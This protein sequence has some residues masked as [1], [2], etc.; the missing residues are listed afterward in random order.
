MRLHSG[1]IFYGAEI[2]VEIECFAQRHI[3]AGCAAR[4]GRGHRPLQGDMI[5]PDRFHSQLIDELSALRGLVGAPF[6]LFPIDLDSRSFEDAARSCGHFR[7]D[8]FAGD[9]G[10][11]MSH[12]SIILY[13]KRP[14][15]S[16]RG[17]V[18]VSWQEQERSA[19][20]EKFCYTVCV[21]S[22][23]GSPASGGQRKL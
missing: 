12:R 17:L 19:A 15:L 16:K 8:S 10:D 5:L 7:P 2:R 1:Q 9:Q 20:V 13:A 18:G 23:A 14:T 3:D 22:I 6:E 11:F 4:D 21:V